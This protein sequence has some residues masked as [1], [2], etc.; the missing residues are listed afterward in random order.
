MVGYG[1]L[2]QCAL[3]RLVSATAINISEKGLGDVSF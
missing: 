1:K 2:C 3:P